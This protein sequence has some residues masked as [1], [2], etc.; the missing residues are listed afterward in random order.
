MDMPLTGPG[1]DPLAVAHTAAIVA[2]YVGRNAVPTADL[3]RLIA[4]THKAVVG[5]G[6]DPEPSVEQLAPAVPVRKSIHPDYIVCLDDGLKF[7]SLKRHLAALGMTPESYR[8]RWGLPI[9]YPMVAPNYSAIRSRLAKNTGL[10]TKG[11]SR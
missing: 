3:P 1:V 5:L 9:D 7:K 4:D 2:A 11:V 8:E 6:A 10:G